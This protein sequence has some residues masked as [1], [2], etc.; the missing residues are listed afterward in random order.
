MELYLPVAYNPI[1]GDTADKI[2]STVTCATPSYEIKA[3][4]MSSLGQF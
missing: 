3:F 4:E 1:A 2:C